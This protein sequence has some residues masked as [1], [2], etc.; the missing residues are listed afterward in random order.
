MNQHHNDGV[1][2]PL[3]RTE[4][5]KPE[6]FNFKKFSTGNH[7][8]D[9]FTQITDGN[10]RKGIDST[11]VFKNINTQ[12]QKKTKQQ[13]QITI[14]VRRIKQYEYDVNIGRDSPPEGYPAE[15]KDLKQYQEKNRDDI[16]QKPKVEHCS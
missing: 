4:I 2:N 10:A 8:Y 1:N 5:R 14:S 3:T 16:Y 7:F 13:K 9:V 11:C 6:F 15:N 12:P